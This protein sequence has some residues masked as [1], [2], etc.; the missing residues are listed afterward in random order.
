MLDFVEWKDVF[1][2]SRRDKE[3]CYR[4]WTRQVQHKWK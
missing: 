3:L 1:I 4:R 2:E